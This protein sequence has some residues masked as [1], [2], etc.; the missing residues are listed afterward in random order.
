LKANSALLLLLLFL[1]FSCGLETYVY[2]NP[3]ESITIRGMNSVS[4]ILPKEQPANYFRYYTIYYRIYISDVN[5]TSITNDT[6]RR[7]I[8]PNLANH[9][10]V[11]D[12]Y[13]TSDNVSPNALESVFE[14]LK[15]HFLYIDA[16]GT[17]RSI[18]T[19]LDI[20]VLGFAV[21]NAMVELDFTVN[22][23]VMTVNSGTPFVLNRAS[24]NFTPR[25]DRLFVNTT[26]TGNLSDSSIISDVVNADVERIEAGSGLFTYV[27]MYIFAVGIDENYSPLYSKPKHI[28]IF[29]LPP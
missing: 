11:L 23:P 25:P 10:N 2:L 17:A 3:V 8:N 24:T 5:L 22:P 16:A 4:I 21:F 28:G 1:F 9:Y 13:T 20:T 6:Q 15:Y 18:N 27:S 26:G 29:R 14:R 12:P 7:Q 19:V